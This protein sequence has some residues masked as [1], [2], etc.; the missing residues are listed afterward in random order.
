MAGKQKTRVG[1]IGTGWIGQH[2]GMNVMANENA[3]L[4]GVFNP[5]EAKARA[6]VERSGSSA[7][8][9]KSDEDLLKRD[10]IDAVIIASPNAAHAEQAVAAAQA[11]KHIY[12][13]KPMA[14][15]LEDCRR[16][17][18][19]VQKAKVKCD[20]GYHRRFSPIPQYAKGLIEDGKLGD[21][22]LVE[23]DYFHHIPGD[24][25]IWSWAGKKDL[26]GTPI[27][28]GNGHNIDLLRYF[29]G[30]VTEVSCYRDIKMPRKIQVETEDIAIINLRFE[31]GAMGRVG[32]FLGP[33]LPFVFTLRLFGT[34]ASV[35]NNRVWLDTI[36]RFYD[37][38]HEEDCIRLP[39]S[40]IWDNVQGGVSETW[41]ACMDTFIDDIRLDRKPF[42]GA[43]SG[44]NTAAVAF[45]AL[46]S[47]AEKKT[48]KPEKL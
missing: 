1:L 9:Y 13:E 14:I 30:E 47:A 40:W 26:A 10:D 19:A 43:E 2:H 15:T 8:V 45:A 6:F 25:D 38:G 16:V 12:L 48:V 20:M 11:G 46:Q 23:S 31:N 24:W 5:T 37:F 35:D 3:E 44:F 18:K 17:V 33:I 39:D 27:H 36:P 7:A 42:N 4:V 21:L 29:C 32:L 22:V 34:R 41:R 28:G